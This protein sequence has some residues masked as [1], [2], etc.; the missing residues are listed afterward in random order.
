MFCRNKFKINFR[1]NP[2]KK[3]PALLA[4]KNRL[5]ADWYDLEADKYFIQLETDDK[6]I[7]MDRE[8]EEWFG[9][10][11][12][13]PLE[14][15]RYDKGFNY[16][17]SIPRTRPLK[18]LE[19][20]CGNGAL[21]RFLIRRNV[22]V[23]SIDIAPKACL[24]LSKTDSRSQP[25]VAC[26]EIL[27]FKSEIYDFVT[28][29]VALHHFNLS[30]CLPEIYR[31]LKPGGR[32]VFMEPLLSSKLFY[33]IRQFVPLKDYES[34]G[35]GGLI[36]QELVAELRRSGFQYDINEFELLTRLEKLPYLGRFQRNLRRIDFALF[37]IC[38]LLKKLAR[39][40]V[41]KLRK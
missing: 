35:G 40:I 28:S 31:V 14:R 23:A 15:Y 39:V 26:S 3:D 30:L 16:F 36:K 10:F 20:G 37:Q 8:Y 24:F 38:P 9:G 2:Y 18:L 21:S 6:L 29:Y 5:E 25:I 13:S 12:D 11:Y 4:E 17:D 32:A 7:L 19:L 1:D 34:P 33:I 22:E 27:P 41:I